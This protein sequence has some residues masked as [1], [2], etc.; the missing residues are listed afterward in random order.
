[1]GWQP[2]WDDV[3]ENNAFAYLLVRDTKESIELLDSDEE[4]DVSESSNEDMEPF[5]EPSN[6]ESNDTNS[7]SFD[8]DKF[9]ENKLLNESPNDLDQDEESN[10]S[11]QFL[12]RSTTITRIHQQINGENSED[13]EYS[14]DGEFSDY[15]DF[16]DADDFSGDDDF[17]DDDDFSDDNDFSDDGENSSDDKLT[18]K[19]VNEVDMIDFADTIQRSVKVKVARH[20]RTD[21]H[22]AEMLTNPT[23]VYANI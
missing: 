3:D 11:I 19:C 18:A 6:Y 21:M 22:F 2:D 23:D 16:S 4:S 8:A 9:R 1:M 14:A 10:D 12:G 15:D 5:L 20:S 7:N 17:R 13:D